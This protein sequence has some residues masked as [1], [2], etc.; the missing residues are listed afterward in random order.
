MEILQKVEQVILQR[1]AA[2]LGVNYPFQFAFL[3]K[4]VQCL[5]IFIQNKF[6]HGLF[7]ILY[8]S[9]RYILA[10]TT[11]QSWEVPNITNF[12]NYVMVAV[13]KLDNVS[14]TSVDFQDK[15]NF[16]IHSGEPLQ[17][18]NHFLDTITTSSLKV[19]ESQSI[20]SSSSS[21][22]TLE[23]VEKDFF[24][25]IY[26]EIAKESEN[27]TEVIK[28]L[29]DIQKVIFFFKNYYYYFF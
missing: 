21:K 2:L 29:N 24:K 11:P 12:D 6:C 20:F 4:P 22:S 19:F 27:I 10:S 28:D 18:V 8:H 23:I 25:K 14:L 26:K 7:F 1:V 15:I 16:M 13:I 17:F 3:K 9:P 5:D